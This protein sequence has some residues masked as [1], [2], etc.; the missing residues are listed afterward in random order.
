MGSIRIISD[1]LCFG[2]HIQLLDTDG[3]NLNQNNIM[4]ISIDLSAGLKAV[5]TVKM[6]APQID[7]TALR[8]D[9][10]DSSPFAVV[11]FWKGKPV[12]EMTGEDC[13][14]AL[15]W[16]EANAAKSLEGFDDRMAFNGSVVERMHE[17]GR[18]I[19]I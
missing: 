18:A 1:G 17:L 7:I 12:S 15:D 5:A 14:D 19:G 9:V 10:Y 11:H 6:H 4:G 3:K 16:L 2:D 8:R 13:K